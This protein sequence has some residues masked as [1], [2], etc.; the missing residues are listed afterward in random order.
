[1]KLLAFLFAAL[2]AANGA[3]AAATK[4][5]EASPSGP[6]VRLDYASYQGKTTKRGI[7]QWSGMRFAAPPLGDLRFQA[8]QDPPRVYGVQK[9]IKVSSANSSIG[10]LANHASG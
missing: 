3:T 8:P 4:G 1:M 2:A 10:N 5:D 7:N 9:A 6:V